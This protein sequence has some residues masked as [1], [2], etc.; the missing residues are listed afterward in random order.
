LTLSEINQ[1]LRNSGKNPLKFDEKLGNLLS[2]DKINKIFFFPRIRLRG[3]NKN[4]IEFAKNSA[5][6]LKNHKDPEKS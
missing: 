1:I 4:H 6:I 2:P 5:K 3:I